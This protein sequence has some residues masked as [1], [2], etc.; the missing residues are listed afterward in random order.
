MNFYADDILVL[1]LSGNIYSYIRY[2]YSNI[3]MTGNHIDYL[4]YKINYMLSYYSNSIV[5]GGFGLIS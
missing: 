5:A 4:P 3:E 1:N 2:N